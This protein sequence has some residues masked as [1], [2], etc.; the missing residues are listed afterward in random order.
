V[1]GDVSR[2]FSVAKLT[3]PVE[4][5]RTDVEEQPT[6]CPSCDLYQDADRDLERE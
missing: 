1:P 3:V 2:N 5:L 6:C 4:S